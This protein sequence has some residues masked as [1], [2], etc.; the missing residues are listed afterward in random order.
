M[1]KTI[2]IFIIFFI[3]VALFSENALIDS[4]KT[5][6]EKTTGIEKVK[7]INRLSKAYWEVDPQKTL[8]YGNQALSLAKELDYK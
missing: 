5:E 6:I 3:S 7:A 4:L 8:E 2:I 1:K